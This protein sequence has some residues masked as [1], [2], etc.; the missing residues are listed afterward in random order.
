M[1]LEATK[2]VFLFPALAVMQ[3]LALPAGRAQSLPAAYD[4]RSVSGASWISDIQDQGKI[5]DC[6]TF[7]SAEAMDSSLLM[8][9]ILPSS[10]VPP[11]PVVSSWALSTAN[12]AAPSLLLTGNRYGTVGF[13]GSEY[14]MLGYV[15][16]GQGVW[17]IPGT[18]PADS[19]TLIT[20]MGGG[21]V[22]NSAPVSPGNSFPT[23]AFHSS[24]PADLGNP[25]LIPPV[26]QAPA[27]T[28]TQVTGLPG[29]RGSPHPDRH[30]GGIAHL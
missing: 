4:L 24:Q 28:A 23:A 19:G 10:T 27:Y 29:K 1:K 5:G 30:L 6:W 18:T 12:G 15:T 14:M 7:A 13:G 26:N 21:P 17:N 20:Q 11:A 22:S 9:G 8:Q 3:F 25:N 16:R 2:A